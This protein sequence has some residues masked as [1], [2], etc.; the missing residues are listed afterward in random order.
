MGGMAAPLLIAIQNEREFQKLCSVVLLD[1][2]L[3]DDPRFATNAARVAARQVVDALI[4]PLFAAR[5][6]G[7]LLEALE[8]AGV[9]C[10]PVWDVPTT[11]ADAALASH[12][13][14]EDP[15]RTVQTVPLPW[16]MS[17]APRAAERGCPRL[18]GDAQEIVQDWLTERG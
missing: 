11:L 6:V 5:P 12:P 3:P 16:I 17:G 7:V 8:R 2:S 9:P 1:P 13:H 15:G 10:G 14:P 4:R 18:D